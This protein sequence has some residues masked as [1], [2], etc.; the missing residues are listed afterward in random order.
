[1]IMPEKAKALIHVKS[2]LK[3][4]GKIYITQTIEKVPNPFMEKIKPLL[5]YFISIDFGSVTYEKDL[6]EVIE[7]SGLKI[8]LMKTISEDSRR[9]AKMIV[10]Q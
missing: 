2:L 7:A 4:N 6:L 10:L 1:M 9:A 5:K 3:E 8:E